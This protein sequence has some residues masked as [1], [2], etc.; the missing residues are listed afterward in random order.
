MFMVALGVADACI[1]TNVNLLILASITDRNRAQGFG[2]FEFVIA[3]ALA[4]GPPLGGI[5]CVFINW[6]LKVA[7]S[8]GRCVCSS[9]RIS[10]S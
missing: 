9:I 8:Q 5:R 7:V 3:I 10:N 1:V 2:M 6:R 4:F